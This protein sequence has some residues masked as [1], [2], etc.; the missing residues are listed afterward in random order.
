MIP[1]VSSKKCILEAFPKIESVFFMLVFTNLIQ[2]SVYLK[3][4][5]TDIV[6]FTLV[7]V[8]YYTFHSILATNEVKS[9]LY[10]LIPEQWYRLFYNGIAIA[11][12]GICIY[13]Y[14]LIEKQWLFQPVGS[15]I[16]I[17]GFLTGIGSYWL[18]GALKGY[19]LDEFTGRGQLKGQHPVKDAILKTDGLN[20]KVRHPLYFGILCLIWGGFCWLPNDAAL[21]IALVSSLYVVVGSRL[22]EHKLAQQF[23]EEYRL[24]REQ[25]PMLLPFGWSSQRN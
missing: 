14:L 2:L 6:T 24:Y 19:D 9:R 5:N 1:Q 15:T 8:A 18:V 23:G 25:V 21:A 3:R 17:G 13:V 16:L 20:A 11:T 10:A 22:E 12:L 7:L 4:M